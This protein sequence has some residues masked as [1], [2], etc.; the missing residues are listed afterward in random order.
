MAN[1]SS[2][3]RKMISTLNSISDLGC[4]IDADEIA[5]AYLL[6]TLPRERGMA[7]E[8]HYIGCPDCVERLQFSEEFV[9]AVRP[10]AAQL[11]SLAAHNE[12]AIQ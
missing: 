1:Y 7:F 12:G 3:S 2:E 6:G 8:E 11:K 4:P 5:E 10:A 9:L